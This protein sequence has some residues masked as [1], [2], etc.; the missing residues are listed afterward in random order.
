M[1]DHVK[2]PPTLDALRARRDEILALAAKYGASNVRVFGSVARG[3]ATA[4][5]DVDILV[6][7]PPDYRLLDHS[8]LWVAL[9]ELLG[10]RVEVSVEANLRESYRPYIMQDAVPL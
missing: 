8:G 4:E 10:V 6:C 5:S 3:E 7:F 2:S 1:I 9:N